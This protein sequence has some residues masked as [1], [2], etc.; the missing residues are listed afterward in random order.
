MALASPCRRTPSTMPSSVHCMA[1]FRSSYSEVHVRTYRNVSWV[2]GSGAL[3]LRELQPHLPIA[4]LIITPAFAHFHEQEQVHPLL[5]HLGDLA[6]SLGAD[7][8]DGLPAIA[9]HDLTLTLSF[10]E[11]RLLDSHR[12][13]LALL[14]AR[15]FDRRLVRQFLVQTQ[16]EL[17]A[18][19]LGGKLPQ[20]RV[21]DL[22]LRIVPWPG[23]HL[24]GKPALEVRHPITTERGDH[25]TRGKTRALVG[26]LSQRQQCGFLHQVDLVEEQHLALRYG[27]EAVEHAA[28]FGIDPTFGIDQHAYDVGIARARPGG[29][30]HGALEPALGCENARRVDEHELRIALDRDAPQQRARGLDLV[31]DDRD[32]GAN[33]SIDE[34]RLAGIGRTNQRDEAAAA[35]WRRGGR[36][37]HRGGP[38]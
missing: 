8:L 15:S 12:A 37:S 31:R 23:R 24:G 33:Q 36:L 2:S 13:V 26:L 14:P 22:V 1:R 17:F 11:D 28:S 32:L 19:D 27:G 16:I 21:S 3:L 30:D 6:A 4:L 25:K 7:R 9:E 20:R 34:R 18:R 38:L 10:D 5:D 29:R 35:A